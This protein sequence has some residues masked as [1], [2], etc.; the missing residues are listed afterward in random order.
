M[1]VF[2]GM[3]A[4]CCRRRRVL[5]VPVVSPWARGSE[6]KGGWCPSRL[7]PQRC[8][9][10]RIDELILGMS[11]VSILH[12]GCRDFCALIIDAER[13]RRRLW[14]FCKVSGVGGFLQYGRGNGLAPSRWCLSVYLPSK[15]SGQR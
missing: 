6:A 11:C 14:C 15:E 3:A 13:S 2:L 8:K 9:T 4:V 10:R 1:R 12:I 5:W 7:L